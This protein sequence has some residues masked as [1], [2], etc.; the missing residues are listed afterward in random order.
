[1]CIFIFTRRGHIFG[2]DDVRRVDRHL[3]PPAATG[4]W[5]RPWRRRRSPLMANRRC[6]P[7][8]ANKEMAPIASQATT[9][10]GISHYENA[11]ESHYTP[12]R[13]NMETDF[14][15]SRNRPKMFRG[16]FAAMI[17]AQNDTRS[18]CKLRSIHSPPSSAQRLGILCLAR[19]WRLN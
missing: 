4:N 5:P 14:E 17:V 7:L 9:I 19:S 12:W 16:S 13:I 18:H 1:M 6:I 2:S 15:A 3:V 8:R 10:G 11:T